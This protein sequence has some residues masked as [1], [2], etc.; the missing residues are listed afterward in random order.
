M[1]GYV[2]LD[3]KMALEI[4]LAILRGQESFS[5][6]GAWDKVYK[7]AKSNKP[8]YISITYANYISSGVGNITLDD[9]DSPSITITFLFISQTVDVYIEKSNSDTVVIRTHN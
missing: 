8:V 2:N 6:R 7:I 5:H 4:A 1:N 9:S 3:E